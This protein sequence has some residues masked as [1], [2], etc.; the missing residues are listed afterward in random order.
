LIP[1]IFLVEGDKKMDFSVTPPFSCMD[2]SVT[3]PFSSAVTGELF[4]GNESWLI[5]VGDLTSF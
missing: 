3:P 2:F 1:D 5:I 4:I